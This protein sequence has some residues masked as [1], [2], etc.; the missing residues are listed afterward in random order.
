MQRCVQR[1]Q[2]CAIFRGAF[3]TCKT[4]PYMYLKNKMFFLFKTILG[5]LA[6]HLLYTNGKRGAR[7]EPSD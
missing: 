2:R 1:A 7:V 4:H 3:H 5:N 6:P